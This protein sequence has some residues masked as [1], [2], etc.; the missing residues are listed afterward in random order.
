[1]FGHKEHLI[2]KKNIP[3]TGMKKKR[4]WIKLCFPCSIQD[5]NSYLSYIECNF[6][7]GIKVQPLGLLCGS[8][9]YHLLLLSD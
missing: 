9:A 4:F 5:L 7:L 3:K 6:I 2:K 1:M 8:V